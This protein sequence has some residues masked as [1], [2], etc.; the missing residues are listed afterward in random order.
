MRAWRRS[1]VGISQAQ[2]YCLQDTG[3]LDL[4][5]AV[6]YVFGWREIPHSGFKRLVA[7]PVLDRADVKASPEHAGGVGR[8]ELSQV[9]ASREGLPAWGAL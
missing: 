9:K 2:L 7:H 8:A 3:D 4:I 1:S 6:V 5:E